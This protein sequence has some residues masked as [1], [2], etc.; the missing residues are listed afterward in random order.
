MSEQGSGGNGGYYANDQPQDQGLNADAFLQKIA[1]ALAM[2]PKADDDKP[3]PN[4][5]KGVKLDKEDGFPKLF[6][7]RND[8]ATRLD[9]D[10]ALM[11]KTELDGW[12]SAHGLHDLFVFLAD[13]VRISEDG[14]QRLPL[15]P[16]NP[17]W[18][19]LQVSLEGARELLSKVA[20]SSLGMSLKMPSR[21]KIAAMETDHIK[22]ALADFVRV[23][24]SLMFCL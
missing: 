1:E 10:E 7:M 20:E 14:T 15:F 5:F 9:G 8:M 6:V 3:K 22:D 13:N 2:R 16:D 4:W 18:E 17:E 24:N 19:D 21:D 23:S 12:L 11:W